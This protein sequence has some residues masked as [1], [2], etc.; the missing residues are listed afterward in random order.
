M[1]SLQDCVGMVTPSHKVVRLPMLMFMH[2]VG[3]VN[4][5]SRSSR[6]K[7]ALI[8]YFDKISSVSPRPFCRPTGRTRIT[9]SIFTAAR[10]KVVHDTRL[11]ETFHSRDVAA[12]SRTRQSEAKQCKSWTESENRTVYGTANSGFRAVRKF[13][14]K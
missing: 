14:E 6:R 10:N 1:A 9:C 4:L 11:G 13:A 12:R 7:I 3:L 2:M 5:A 8:L